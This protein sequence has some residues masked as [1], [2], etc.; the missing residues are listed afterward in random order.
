MSEAPEHRRGAAVAA[1]GTAASRL[2]GLVRLAATT[3]ALGVTESRLADTYNLANTTPTVIHEL[4]IGGILSSVLLRAYVEV[5]SRDGQQQAW[6]FIRRVTAATMLL[7]GVLTV[8]VA[9]AAPLIFKLYTLR[10]TG[11]EAQAQQVLGTFLLRLFAAQI[12]FYGLSYIATAVL[13]AHRKFGVPMFAPVL[14]N[15]L[16]S[17]TL[18]VFARTVPEALRTAERL[19]TRGVLLLGIGTTVGV[20]IQGIYPFLSMRRLGFRLRRGAGLIDP[21]FG[22][23]L[24]LSGYMAGYV[25]TNMAGLWVALFLANQ[26]QGGTSAYQYAF[27]FFQLPHGLLAVSIVTAIFPTLT[28]QAVAG[29][30][31][32]FA[33]TLSRGLRAVAFFVVPAVAGYLAIAPNLVALMLEHGITTQAS[34]DLI[35]TVL[36]AWAPGIF[37]FSTFYVLL[38]AF[39]A[40]GDTRTPMIIN[41]GAFALNVVLNLAAFAIFDDP[42]LKVAGLAA[43]HAGSYLLASVLA[44]R[45]LRRR[46]GPTVSAGYPAAL[47]KIVLAATATGLG[48]WLAGDLVAPNQLANGFLGDILQV[49]AAT[50]SGLLIYAGAAKALGLEETQWIFTIAGRRR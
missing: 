11:S 44:L 32:E 47:V 41:L 37:F 16:V 33:R 48:A 31:E 14:N 9:L 22:R 24:R 8:A 20:A 13:N 15:L 38:R 2:T 7:L 39:Y 29:K 17:A 26:V 30:T 50:A 25:V 42:T 18:V 3:Y 5:R 1:A 36:R 28:E 10:A 46:I 27:V 34:T 12:L 21:R 40:L 23:L 19:P 45:S 49:L 43:G 6:L 35:A 4:V